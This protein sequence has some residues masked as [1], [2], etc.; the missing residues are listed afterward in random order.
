[1]AQFDIITLFPE[2]FRE[3]FDCGVVGRAR[4]GGLI[5]IDVHDL[6]PFGIGKHRV[7]DDTPFGGGDGMVMMVEP[8]ARAIET[9]LEGK[10]DKTHVILTTP[11]GEVF[12][13]N[14]ARRLATMDRRIA[15][16]CGRYAG[17]DE[18]VRDLLVDEEL[19]IGDYVLS[20]GEPAAI[21]IV[22]AVARLVPGVLGNEDSVINDSFPY[23]LEEAQYTRPREWNGH[24]VPEVLLSG[25]HAK[26]AAWRAMERLERTCRNRPDLYEKA[27]AI[28]KEL[29]DNDPKEG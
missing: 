3:V 4:D 17:V 2:F 16:I 24:G 27:A 9:V 23:L 21:V 20:G 12:D 15:I 25:N 18:R 22:D 7:V 29:K 28:L 19:S 6:R 26:I 11:Q 13:Q 10:R 5:G 8:V 14:A 1:M